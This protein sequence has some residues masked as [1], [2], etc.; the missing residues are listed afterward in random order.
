MKTEEGMKGFSWT[1]CEMAMALFTIKK[2][3]FTKDSG[4]TI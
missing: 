4:K 3:A 2:E 1:I